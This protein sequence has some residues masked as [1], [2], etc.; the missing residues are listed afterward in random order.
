[1]PLLLIVCHLFRHALAT[2]TTPPNYGE[3]IGKVNIKRGMLQGDSLSPI[4]FILCLIPLSM[5]LRNVK[6]GYKF[7]TG[8]ATINHLLFMDE[9]KL[10][11]KNEAHIDSLVKTVHL[12]TKDWY[13][14]W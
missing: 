3:R 1:M 8:Q 12:F 2:L 4:L 5:L 10:F 7:R 13:E 9:L 6:A 11:G 14:V